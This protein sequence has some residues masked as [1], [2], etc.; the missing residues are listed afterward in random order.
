VARKQPI[1]ATGPATPKPVKRPRK[2]IPAALKAIAG[3]VVVALVFL[4]AA[5]LGG[6]DSSVN[7]GKP[8]PVPTASPKASEGKQTP[9]AEAAE[10]LGYPSFA[11]N[12]TTRV[13]GSD[14]ASTAAGVALAVFPWQPRRSG[15]RRWRSP[16]RGNGRAPSLPPC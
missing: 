10:E 13:G 15:R 3:L 2:Q 14:P 6:G 12:N 11:T 1:N 4:V 9:T 7:S 8:A 16:T 5:V